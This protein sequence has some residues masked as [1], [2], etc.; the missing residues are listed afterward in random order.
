MTKI[1]EFMTGWEP[2]SVS[3]MLAWTERTKE[4]IRGTV[5]GKRKPP[6]L[7][8][9]DLI[10]APEKRAGLLFAEVGPHFMRS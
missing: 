4:N 7:R 3:P 6:N 10:R 1:R 2:G 9:F 8:P 5:D